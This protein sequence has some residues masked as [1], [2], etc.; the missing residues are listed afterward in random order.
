MIA[1]VLGFRQSISIVM[2]NA[3]STS[4]HQE[5]GTDL[6]AFRPY[7]HYVL[8]ERVEYVWPGA[9]VKCTHHFKERRPRK[10]YPLGSLKSPS[11]NEYETVVSD[12]CWPHTIETRR[13][14]QA[15]LFVQ[16]SPSVLISTANRN[17]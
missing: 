15:Q 7:V 17:R 5:H 9:Q 1:K 16:G 3:P 2:N 8:T 6:P 13:S 12:M 4:S 14:K 11:C 10:R